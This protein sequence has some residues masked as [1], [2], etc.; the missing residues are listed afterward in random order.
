M[1][2]F[3]S[4]S[5][6]SDQNLRREV[7]HFPV[8][9]YTLIN[10]AVLELDEA[11]ADG[12][13]VALLIGESDSASTFRV[14]QLRICINSRI[15]HSTIQPVHDHSKFHFKRKRSSHQTWENK[16]Q[17][18]SSFF[19]KIKK[20]NRIKSFMLF[21][22][23]HPLTHTLA[24]TCSHDTRIRLA[25]L[26]TWCT[27]IFLSVLDSFQVC[28]NLS[29]PKQTKKS[30]N[31]I[32]PSQR[33]LRFYCFIVKLIKF[34]PYSSIPLFP[35]FVQPFITRLL[36]HNSTLIAHVK[37]TSQLPSIMANLPASSTEHS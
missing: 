25:S 24:P 15:T 5:L 34:L 1:S 36:P 13:D 12:S 27:S 6:S 31:S 29:H 3:K 30:L 37:V 21:S 7:S 2:I 35:Y 9:T 11:R 20:V 22:K 4:Y 17:L 26:L 14:F 33:L 8:A 10:V 28:C 18:W 19:K 16:E 32:S 23:S